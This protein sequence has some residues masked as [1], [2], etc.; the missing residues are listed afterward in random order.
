MQFSKVH[1]M[2]DINNNDLQMLPR[3]ECNPYSALIPSSQSQLKSPVMTK[4]NG[5]LL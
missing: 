3:I 2:H 1:D 4:L 5:F